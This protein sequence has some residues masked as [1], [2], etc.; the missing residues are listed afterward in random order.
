[1]AFQVV[2]E[3]YLP[4]SGFGDVGYAG[5]ISQRPSVYEIIPFGVFREV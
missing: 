5:V 2:I 4:V 3:S 1:M